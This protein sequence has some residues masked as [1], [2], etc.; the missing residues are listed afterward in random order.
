MDGSL[1]QEVGINCS[2]Q[3]GEEDEQAQCMPGVL[4]VAIVGTDKEKSMS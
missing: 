2:K 1:L 4:E 3:M